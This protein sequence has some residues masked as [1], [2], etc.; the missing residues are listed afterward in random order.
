MIKRNKEY[1]NKVIFLLKQ[2]YPN[3]KIALNY[4][5]NFQLLIA[6]ILSAQTTD[7]AVNKITPI[8]F[9]TFPALKSLADGKTEQIEN[10]IKSIGLYR[11]KAKNIKETA[12]LVHTR[13]NDQVPNTMAELL[14]LPGVARKTANVVLGNAYGIIVGIAVDTHVAR[15]SQR[16]GFTENK[17]PNRI[18]QDLM[19]LFSNK[20][21]FNL[22]YILIEHGRKI[23]IAKKPKCDQCFLNHI[24]PSA[25]KFPHFGSMSC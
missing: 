19:K 16:L 25:F 3:A 8:L 21:W 10:I 4:S 12:K 7:I 23:C 13:F 18:E 24:C 20:D 22:T 11:N 2:N 5:N 15:L 6:V 1:L 14:T 17:D 9:K